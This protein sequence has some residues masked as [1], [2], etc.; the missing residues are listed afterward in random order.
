MPTPD[1]LAPCPRPNRDRRSTRATAIVEIARA[2]TAVAGA[3]T[4]L[5]TLIVKFA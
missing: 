2:V 3:L 4:I 5:L 1:V